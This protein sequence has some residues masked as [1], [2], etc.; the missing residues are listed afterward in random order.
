MAFTREEF[1]ERYARLSD[2]QLIRI[3]QQAQDLV[4][5]AYEAARAEFASRDLAESRLD[6]PVGKTIIGPGAFIET[7]RSTLR[8]LIGNI[9]DF[10]VNKP[11]AVFPILGK[12]VW[13]YTMF[14]LITLVLTYLDSGVNMAREFMY[15]DDL[16]LIIYF[17]AVSVSTLAN[18]ITG[19]AMHQPLK[20]SWHFI[21][22]W[23]ITNVTFLVALK[24]I[25]LFLYGVFF[26]QNY[27]DY[28]HF[29]LIYYDS[30]SLSFAF[31]EVIYDIP[32]VLV[33]VI[34][35]TIAI[36]AALPGSKAYFNV[37]QTRLPKI[38]RV[39]TVSISLF[40]LAICIRFFITWLGPNL[41]SE[42]VQEDNSFA[43]IL[44]QPIEN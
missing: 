40:V 44:E 16:G 35:S 22:Y 1:Q 42:P 10:R 39:F 36:Y 25:S 11:E 28:I 8:S 31:W 32:A 21:Q 13:L 20:W 2:E 15:F 19:V 4:P 6:E 27:W 26:H 24:I 38:S 23:I 43:P 14:T 30:T 33:L 3:L 17:G 9:K 29:D 37:P 5:A 41:I 7:I 34:Y 18:L 12:I